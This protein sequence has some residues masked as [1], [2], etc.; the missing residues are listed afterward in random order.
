MGVDWK[1]LKERRKRV[2]L[3]SDEELIE[4]QER[5]V[6]NVLAYFEMQKGKGGSDDGS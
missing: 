3:L 2:K 1:L 5:V 6:K 4:V